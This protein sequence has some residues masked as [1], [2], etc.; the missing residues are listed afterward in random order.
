MSRVDAH[1]HFWRLDRRDY[2]WLD[3]APDVL[4]RDHLPDELLT[5][6]QRHRIN[7]TLAVQ[8]APT[9]AETEYLIKLAAQHVFLAGVV[10]WVDVS[11]P[12]ACDTLE[13]LAAYPSFKGIRPMLQD[14]EDPRWLLKNGLPE[15]FETLAQQRLT[16]DALVLPHQLPTLVEFVARF[17]ELPIVVD[18]AAK[19]RIDG[20]LDANWL[21]AMRDLSQSPSVHCKYS[22]LA[23]EVVGEISLET[24][25]PHVEAL[26]E[27]FTHQR[28]IWGSDWPVVN[29]VSS[30]GEWLKLSESLL[31]GSTE[32]ELQ[33]VYGENA[34]RFYSLEDL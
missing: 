14:I 22:G 20:T 19:P 30:Y 6:T 2:G 3:G 27:L 10:G 1:Q 8:A 33:A 4:K 9:V 24:L 28:L 13:R 26:I 12:E 15:V 7:Q 29:L 31:A 34:R 16:F 21:A 11:S 25:Q 18:H 23:T 5:E 17:P 32:Q